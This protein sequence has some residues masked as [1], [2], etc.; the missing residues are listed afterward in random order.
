MRRT[1]AC[2][3]YLKGKCTRGDNCKYRH[4]SPGESHMIDD[5]SA[6]LM[7]LQGIPTATAFAQPPPEKSTDDL[8][9]ERVRVPG[10][11][12]TVL[13]GGIK[14]TFSAGFVPSDV[15]FLHKHYS[16]PQI[17]LVNTGLEFTWYQP[18]CNVWLQFK[19]QVDAEGAI[20]TLNGNTI[21]VSTLIG[22]NLL[23]FPQDQDVDQ[24]PATFSSHAYG[25]LFS[26]SEHVLTFEASVPDHQAES[27]HEII[28]RP[29]CLVRSSRERH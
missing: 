24:D 29:Q 5:I 25:S 21:R 27:Y 13:D 4:S 16:M 22:G 20:Q 2:K 8:K 23:H 14:S 3:F 15:T 19:S 17:S 1:P 12:T 7:R 10:T 11:Y 6:L 26:Y 28:A 18:T 9:I